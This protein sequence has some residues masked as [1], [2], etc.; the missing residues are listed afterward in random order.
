[1]IRAFPQS[2]IHSP[3]VTLFVETANSRET[4]FVCARVTLHTVAGMGGIIP[5]PAPRPGDIYLSVWEI[6]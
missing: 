6:P 4:D 3:F 2:F 5:W 1:M